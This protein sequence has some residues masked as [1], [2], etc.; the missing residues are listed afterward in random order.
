[1]R[2]GEAGPRERQA[3]LVLWLLSSAQIHTVSRGGADLSRSIGTA[4]ALLQ[5]RGQAKAACLFQHKL[6]L[7][8]LSPWTYSSEIV[9][10]IL[11]RTYGSHAAYRE[12]NKIIFTYLSWPVLSSPPP[13]SA[14]SISVT[15]LCIL[16]ECRIGLLMKLLLSEV[17]PHR[18]SS[19]QKVYLSNVPS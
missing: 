7:Y 2:A 13:C 12:V 3:G 15:T 1:M 17:K 8:N 9:D 19:G 16:E 18:A 4:V 14:H 11:K 5:G 10:I 6:G